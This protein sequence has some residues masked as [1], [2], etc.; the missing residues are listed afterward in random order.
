MDRGLS[1][2]ELGAGVGRVDVG[3][4]LDG[5]AADGGTVLRGKQRAIYVSDFMFHSWKQLCQILV[6]FH[7]D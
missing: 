7:S 3:L 6:L 5:A 1:Y 4:F 2:E